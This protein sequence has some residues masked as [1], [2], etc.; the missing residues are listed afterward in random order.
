VKVANGSAE[1]NFIAVWRLVQPGDEVAMLV[2]AYM[3]THGLA[4]AAGARVVEIPL[5]E[6]H[7]WQ[8]DPDEIRATVGERTRL[9]IVTNPGNPTGAVL[10][11]E[12]RAAVIESAERTGAWILADEVYTGAELDGQPTP[13]FWG[14]TERV[15]ATGSLSKAYGLPG[16]RIGWAVAPEDMSADLWART[17][18][19]TISPGTLT[20]RLAVLALADDVRPRLLARTRR[21][22]RDGVA[23][24]EAWFAD[25]GTFH[26]Q[27][28]HAGAI[29]F[30][31]YDD[32]IESL[33]L[34]ERL[35][36]EHSVLIVPGAHFGLGRYVRF[37]FGLPVP[38]LRAAL[39]RM[40]ELLD[41]IAPPAVA[42]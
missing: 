42:R 24:L 19:T 20:D 15:I 39:A 17:D 29:C 14:R 36:V 4:R 1:A 26:H 7:G 30:A 9:V 21:I 31:R 38:E 2:P 28:P 34:A 5:H 32:P 6:A 40:G 27:R 37:G 13:S 8:P 23:T 12:A 10:S 3:Q 41:A 11:D 33:D 18:Y 22:I 25:R 35:R 16:L